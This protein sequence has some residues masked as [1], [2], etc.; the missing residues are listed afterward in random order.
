MG[1]QGKGLDARIV[2][3]SS[4]ENFDVSTEQVVMALVDDVNGIITILVVQLRSNDHAFVP[5]S[6]YVRNSNVAIDAG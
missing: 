5:I 4:V 1:I 2:P 6:T 3:V